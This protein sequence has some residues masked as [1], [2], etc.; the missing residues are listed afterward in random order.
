MATPVATAV[1]ME[2]AMAVAMEEAMAVAMEVAMVVATGATGHCA[3]E[4]ATLLAGRTSLP[5]PP[6]LLK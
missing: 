5:K 3:T 4:D 2:A 6:E 1:A